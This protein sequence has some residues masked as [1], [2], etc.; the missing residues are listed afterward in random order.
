MANGSSQR[1]VSGEGSEVRKYGNRDWVL[2]GWKGHNHAGDS[3]TAETETWDW[4]G[5]GGGAMTGTHCL[6]ASLLER[7][8]KVSTCPAALYV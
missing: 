2:L 7:N 4:L 3:L 8:G 1:G 5:F 6:S